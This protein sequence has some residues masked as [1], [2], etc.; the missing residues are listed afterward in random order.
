MLVVNQPLVWYF[1][2]YLNRTLVTQDALAAINAFDQ[3]TV[4]C[5]SLSWGEDES[6]W[7]DA[8]RKPPP[9]RSI[10]VCASP[11]SESLLF[12][13]LPWTCRAIDRRRQRSASS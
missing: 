1:A 4:S 3:A 7:D 8:V 5:V 11:R 6:S 10:N 2:A 12:A 13:Y 9:Q